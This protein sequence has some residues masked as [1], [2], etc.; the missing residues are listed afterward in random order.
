MGPP[1][2]V[3]ELRS[4]WPQVRGALDDSLLIESREQYLR[5]ALSVWEGSAGPEGICQPQRAAASLDV[6][7]LLFG[8]T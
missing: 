8:D 4:F 2:V 6:L 5:H 3:A 7:C 1:E